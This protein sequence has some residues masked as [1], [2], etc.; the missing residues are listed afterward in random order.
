MVLGSGYS[1]A[2]QYS[3][4]IF[5][6]VGSSD[7]EVKLWL[8]TISTIEEITD[9]EATFLMKNGPERR[10]RFK[11]EFGQLVDALYISNPDGGS[12]RVEVS[13]VKRVKFLNPPRMDKDKHPMLDD[14]RYS[15]YT[16]EKLPA[17]D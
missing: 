9:T 13:K 14:W 4:H 8:D 1:V 3:T 10:L 17:V 12:E 11:Q 16:G 6:A 7:S 2:N 15:P 5:D